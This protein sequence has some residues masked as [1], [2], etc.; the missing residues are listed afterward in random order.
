M[1]QSL[2]H[3]DGPGMCKTADDAFV[4]GPNSDKLDALTE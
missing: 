1:K 4:L 2:G 3:L